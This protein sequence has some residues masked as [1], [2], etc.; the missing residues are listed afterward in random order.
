M[1]KGQSAG[2]YGDLQTV[3]VLETGLRETQCTQL[4]ITALH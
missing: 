4:K 3:L 2:V 1:L